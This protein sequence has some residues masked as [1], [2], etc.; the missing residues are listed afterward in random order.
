MNHNATALMIMSEMYGWVPL[1]WGDLL[2]K[3]GK[4]NNEIH[5]CD[6]FQMDQAKLIGKA[7]WQIYLP[8]D[9]VGKPLRE[10]TQVRDNWILE[11]YL[12]PGRVYGTTIVRKL[13]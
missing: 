5:R 9:T 3:M 7:P 8:P 6:S 13:S 11:I 12:Q 4:T 2:N 1:P 10:N